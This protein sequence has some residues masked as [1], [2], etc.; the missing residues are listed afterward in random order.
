MKKPDEV[1]EPDNKK[2]KTHIMGEDFANKHTALRFVIAKFMTVSRIPN[3]GVRYLGFVILLT[4]H[5]GVARR[6][7]S[8]TN[9][10]ILETVTPAYLKSLEMWRPLAVDDEA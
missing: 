4:E 5:D 3:H 1:D 2:Y 8:L 9:K 10:E 6:V 7:A